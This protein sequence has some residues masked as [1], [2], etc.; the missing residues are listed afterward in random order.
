MFLVSTSKTIY[1]IIKIFFCH[2]ACIDRIIAI[3]Q[4]SI[5]V[6]IYVNVKPCAGL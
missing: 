3:G 5:R 2:Y 1:Q 4:I 6:I